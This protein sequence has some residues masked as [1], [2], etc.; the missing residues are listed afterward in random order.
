MQSNSEKEVLLKKGNSQPFMIRAVLYSIFLATP[1]I[2]F[3]V[4]RAW[5]DWAIETEKENP[6]IVAAQNK[7]PDLPESGA[8][9]IKKIDEQINLLIQKSLKGEST[10]TDDA[11]QKEV[12]RLKKLR[13]GVQ[14]R[15]DPDDSESSEEIDEEL[16]WW[17][18]KDSD[19]FIILT[20]LSIFSCV[21]AFGALGAAVSLISRSRNSKASDDFVSLKELISIQTV[22]AIFALILSLIFMGELVAGT[23]FPRAEIFYRIIYIPAA[24][25]KLL[26]WSFIAGFSERF[27]PKFLE[28]L[29]KKANDTESDDVVR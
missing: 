1:F 5:P 14:T 24:F 12:E 27:V 4:L 16:S 10:L 18:N 29:S 8:D 15:S 13:G 26:V 7:K 19:F 20:R 23:L 3:L 6:A 25:A 22:G 17:Q 28:G 2:L 11:V 21:L 9:T